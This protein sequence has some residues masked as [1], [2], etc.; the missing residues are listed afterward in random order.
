MV[1]WFWPVAIFAAA[2]VVGAFVWWDVARSTRGRVS[3]HFVCPEVRRDV[4]VTFRSD[5]LDPDYFEDVVSCS[6]FG[7]GDPVACDRCCLGLSKQELAW[8]ERRTTRVQEPA[9]V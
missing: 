2:L 7:S 6:E 8:A 1:T 4:V 9:V 5:Y 3:R